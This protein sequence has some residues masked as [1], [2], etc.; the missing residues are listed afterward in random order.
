MGAADTSDGRRPNTSPR[1][2]E[3]LSGPKLRE[4]R[5]RAGVTTADLA[6]RMG[7]NRVRVSQIEALAQPPAETTRRY[8]NA[9][10][11]PEA[12]LLRAAREF[13]EALEVTP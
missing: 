9:L 12:R 1:S 13:S 3:P 4:L 8:L 11:D 7:V 6:A 2:S 10:A 5:K